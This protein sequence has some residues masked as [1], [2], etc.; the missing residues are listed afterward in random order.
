MALTKEQLAF[1][2]K[3]LAALRSG[4]YEQATGE[5]RDAVGFCCLGV[6]CDISGVGKWEGPNY[7]PR[8]GMSRRHFPPYHVATLFGIDEELE[9]ALSELNDADR[10]GFIGESADFLEIADTIELLTLADMES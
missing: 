1:R 10:P 9:N 8:R 5:L 4:E 6:A 2:K 7:Y 3:W